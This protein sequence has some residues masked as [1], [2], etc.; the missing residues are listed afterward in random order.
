MAA[1]AEGTRLRQRDDLL[2]RAVRL[3]GGR[4]LGAAARRLLDWL[5]DEA[6][7]DWSRA[8]LDSLS[9]RAKR[10]AKRPAMGF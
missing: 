6:A 7:I 9:V 8:S 2:A 3:A 4:R 5:G 10:R 1:V